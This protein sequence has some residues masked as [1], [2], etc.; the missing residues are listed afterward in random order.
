MHSHIHSV[1]TGHWFS[2]IAGQ[3]RSQLAIDSFHYFHKKSTIDVDGELNSSLSLVIWYWTSVFIFRIV[4]S[5]QAAMGVVLP[6]IS[7]SQKKGFR[8]QLKLMAVFE[9]MLK[10]GST[11]GT[12]RLE[13]GLFLSRVENDE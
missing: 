12:P 13:S 4:D 5:V 8:S 1:V 9:E 3:T 11:F 10:S 7:N 2:I 6:Y